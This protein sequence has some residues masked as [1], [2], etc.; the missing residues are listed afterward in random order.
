MAN[1]CWRSTYIFVESPPVP[2]LIFLHLLT[3]SISLLEPPDSLKSHLNLLPL[4]L[5]EAC[6]PSVPPLSLSSSI[7]LSPLAWFL[8]PSRLQWWSHW[9]WNFL[10]S[11]LRPILFILYIIPF[12]NMNNALRSLQL[13][14][15]AAGN[16]LTGTDKWDH[17]TAVLPSFHWLPVKS[18]IVFKVLLQ[19]C[20]V[21]RHQ[22]PSY[23]EESIV[24][25]NPNRPLH[26]QNASLLMVPIIKVELVADS[27]S[28]FKIRLSLR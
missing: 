4:V 5:A 12:E 25:Y 15:N 21:V 1:K 6:L 7:L 19:T 17:M 3:Y 18:R 14:K 16:V 2:C 22:A 13:I 20:K 24:P 26:F 11:V 8:H 28:T 23:P 10:S 9:S 27:L